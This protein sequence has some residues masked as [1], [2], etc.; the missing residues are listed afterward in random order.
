MFPLSVWASCTSLPR[1][2]R[3]LR[4]ATLARAPP[5][6][7]CGTR[8]SLPSAP[9]S[10][11]SYTSRPRA[12]REGRRPGPRSAALVRCCCYRSWGC[13][14]SRRRM[15]TASA[16]PLLKA[17]RLVPRRLCDREGPTGRAPLLAR[18]WRTRLCCPSC[19]WHANGSCCPSRRRRRQAPPRRLSSGAERPDGSSKAA[20]GTSS[21]RAALATAWRPG[22]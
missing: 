22:R 1:P 18:G 11:R 17:T 3:R 16:A 7:S 6:R 21:S 8:S 10:R 15:G 20:W 12:P 5:A 4:P 19:R 14:R 9:S 2:A 13:C